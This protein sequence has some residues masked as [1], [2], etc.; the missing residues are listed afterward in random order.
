MRSSTRLAAII[1]LTGGCLAVVAA[2][3]V[4]LVMLL[5]WDPSISDA[6]QAA[7]A[8]GE[9]AARTRPAEPARRLAVA[10][11]DAWP[12]FRGSPALTGVSAGKLPEK[13][14]L[15]WRAR[16]GDAVKSSAAIVGGKVYV[17]SDDGNVYALDLKTGRRVWAHHVGDAV[18]ASP[19]VIGGVVYVGSADE[20]LY[21]IDAATGRRKWKYRTGDKILG[22]AN[23]TPAARGKGAW[24]VV[25]SYD[26]KVHCVDAAGR[27]VWTYETD[28]FVNGAPAVA[29]GRVVFG[30]CDANVHV[31]K[32]ADGSALAKVEVDAYIAASPALAGR[33]A[34]IGHYGNKL[35][36]VDV[37]AG[38]VVWDYSDP[39]E[40]FFSSA[41]VGAGVVL[42]GSRDKQLHCIDRATGKG[43]WTFRTR[44]AVDSS[45]VLCGDKVVFGSNDGRLYVVGLA[46]GNKLWSYDTGESIIASPAVAAGM[47]VIGSENGLIYA[48]GPA[49]GAPAK[50]PTIDLRTP[51]APVSTRPK[52]A[53]E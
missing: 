23:W 10:P 32:A 9:Q 27:K 36:C 8:T 6:E 50:P 37:V 26:N 20:F 33:H 28:S 12:M 16:T 52:A 19:T 47:I 49:A 41:A 24:I 14:K 4:A 51:R 15:Y 44:G 21:A 29:N 22:A 45:L 2:M 42:V 13:P 31:A 5:A 18:E 34:F 1:F 17:G 46:K 3:V 53:A 38:E 48:F 11:A 43:V 40:P 7:M 39:D 35:V 30:G 25:G